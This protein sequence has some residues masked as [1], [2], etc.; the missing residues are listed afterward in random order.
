MEE[1]RS[2]S[3]ADFSESSFS[4][5]TRMAFCRSLRYPFCSMEPITA[6]TATVMSTSVRSIPFRIVQPSSLSP[7]ALTILSS[8]LTVSAILGFTSR[9]TRL[10]AAR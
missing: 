6:F 5:V 8:A 9:I 10:F 3:A 4:T 2:W 1:M 7:S